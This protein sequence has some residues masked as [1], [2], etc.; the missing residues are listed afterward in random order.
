MKTRIFLTAETARLLNVSQRTLQRRNKQAEPRYFKPQGSR[1][2]NLQL[3]KNRPSL[4]SFKGKSGRNYRLCGQ[5]LECVYFRPDCIK[6]AFEK[7]LYTKERNA[8]EQKFSVTRGMQLLIDLCELYTSNP[9]AFASVD[10]MLL[11]SA[12]NYG[13]APRGVWQEGAANQFW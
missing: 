1:G 8:K 6:D 3:F 9:A 2:E 4:S 13:Y 10:K 7:Q 5:T 11:N 12:L